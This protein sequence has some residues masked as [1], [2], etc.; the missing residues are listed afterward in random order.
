MLIQINKKMI[1][2]TLILILLIGA[3]AGCSNAG[4]AAKV[5][6]NVV[7]KVNGKE[8]DY[9][10]FK[11]NFS[12]IEKRYNE[13]YTENIWSQEI[14]GKT[15]LEIVKGQVLDKLV[16][17]ELINQEA[18]KKGISVEDAKI[19][20]AY[21]GFK[22]RL[23]QDEE[24]KKFY[25]ENNLDESFVKDQIKMGLLVQEYEKALFDEHGL[26]D[27]EKL[28]E[29]T[30]DYV[31]QV[32]A[33][34]ILVKDEE[35]AKEIINKIKAGG[36]FTELAKENSKDPS[37]KDNNGDLGYFPRGAMVKQFEEAAFSMNV[38]EISDPVKTDYGYHII[39]LEGKKTIDDL[40]KEVSEEELELEKQKAE[41]MIKQEEF[42]KEIEKLKSEGNIEKFEENLK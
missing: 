28:D 5:D 16:T 21:N 12:I 2:V 19:E 7:A 17:E 41:A 35:L 15:V 18:Q 30:K 34:H 40:K 13:W 1:S 4:G 20:E 27:K 8:I 36:D 26:N 29:L 10:S 23:E 6:E 3:L 42:I 33:K 22:E 25:E 38:G 14:N 39:K 37:V 32:S 9:D 24:L 31:V 11:K